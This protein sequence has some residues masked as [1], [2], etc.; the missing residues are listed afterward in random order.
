MLTVIQSRPEINIPK[1]M[2]IQM[3]TSFITTLLYLIVLFYAITDF[4]AVLE[5]T[6]EFP[7]TQIYYQVAGSKA[8]AVGLTVMVFLPLVGSVM[9][10]ILV[11]SRVF[12]TLARDG[13]VPFSDHFA[14]VSPRWANPFNSILLIPVFCE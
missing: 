11:S 7:L 6:A 9:G 5:V 4:D 13:A 12:W 1:V 2:G 10:C 14:R 8:G 3:T